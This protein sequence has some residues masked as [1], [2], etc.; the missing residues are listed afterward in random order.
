M[1]VLEKEAGTCTGAVI[2]KSIAEFY[3]PVFPVVARFVAKMGGSF[4]DAKDIFHDALVIYY[5]KQLNDALVPAL[6][7]E[8]Y[9]VGIAKHVWL[10]K[11]RQQKGRIAFG[12]EEL[13]IAMPPEEFREADNRLLALLQLTGR[14]CLELL[15]A[16]YYD[17]LALADIARTFGYLTVRSATVQKYKCLEKVR[18]K[19]KAKAITYEDLAE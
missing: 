5:E 14:R 6:S 10:R 8:A 18:D 13:E 16:F 9:L 17:K 4:S 7:A 1:E 15:Q 19:V 2:E 12:P 11:F 3:E